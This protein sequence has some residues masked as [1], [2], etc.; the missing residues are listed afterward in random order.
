[1]NT[2]AKPTARPSAAFST[3]FPTIIQS[4][5]GFYLPYA[6]FGAGGPRDTIEL[7]G[8]FKT[9]AAAERALRRVSMFVA[10]AAVAV[11]GLV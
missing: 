7:L 5:D 1:V 3:T 11:G 2:Q 9:R 6:K 4:D 10:N 8:R